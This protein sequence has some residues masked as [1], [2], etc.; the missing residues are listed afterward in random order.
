MKQRPSP[1]PNQLHPPPSPAEKQKMELIV[2]QRSETH[3][4]PASRQP[5]PGTLAAWNQ[6]LAETPH[7]VSAER[8]TLGAHGAEGMT[9]R[10]SG[11][12][13]DFTA[14]NK[15][16]ADRQPT[17]GPSQSSR[18]RPRSSED[19]EKGSE[20]KELSDDRDLDEEDTSPKRRRSNR[21][22]ESGVG[23]QS[24]SLLSPTLGDETMAEMEESTRD[25][26]TRFQ[27]AQDYPPGVWRTDSRREQ[28]G[29]DPRVGGYGSF[30]DP[31]TVGSDDGSDEE[32]D[33]Q[34]SQ[35]DGEEDE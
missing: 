11:F 10:G 6:K 13:P 9:A 7:P 27:R 33:E 21:S 29:A 23:D 22:S 15:P 20:S 4:E 32:E 24:I 19:A 16:V 2:S 12:S 25:E 35:G 14:V 26:R 8:L 17:P 31:M 3:R 1:P 28:A 18:K 30:R 5:Q 34:S